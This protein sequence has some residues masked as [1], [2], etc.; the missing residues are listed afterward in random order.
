MTDGMTVFDRP[1]VRR[2]RDRAASGLAAHDF[3]L[4]EV[5][6]RLDDRLRDV[7]RQFDC[8]LDLGCHGGQT[9][10]SLTALRDAACV[11]HCDASFG[12]ARRAGGHA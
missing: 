6:S 8:A 9:R 10:E 4:R 3:L 12:M 2:H 1:G 11:L 5:G 7:S